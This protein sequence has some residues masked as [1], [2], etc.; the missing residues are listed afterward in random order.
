MRLSTRIAVF[1]WVCLFPI[2]ARGD[3]IRTVPKQSDI[4]VNDVVDKQKLVNYLLDAYGIKRN[5]EH[6]LPPESKPPYDTM[7]ASQ[8]LFI[9][10]RF[11]PPRDEL[12]KEFKDNYA[13]DLKA[14]DAATQGLIAILIDSGN[15]YRNVIGIMEP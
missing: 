15:A 5:F 13:D 4:C 10:E 14:L 8:R 11:Q 12:S 1:L 6:S 3:P 7:P 9:D 2:L